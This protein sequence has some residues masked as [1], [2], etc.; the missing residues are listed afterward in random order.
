MGKH[1]WTE[2][3]S[4][5]TPITFVP[6]EL[7]FC[8]T[9]SR[10][11]RRR[12]ATPQG[13]NRL[14]IKQMRTSQKNQK[15]GPPDSAAKPYFSAAGLSFLRRLE[16][17]NRRDWFDPRKEEFTRE[18]KQPMLALIDAVNAA[19]SDFAPQHLRPA[20]KCMMRIYR[21]TRFSPDKR[22]YKSHVAAWW[23]HAGLEKT[24]GGGYYLHVSHK[25]VIVAA[26]VYMPEREQLLAIRT[27]LLEHHQQVRRVLEDKK[28]RRL[29]DSFSSMPLS[30]APKGFPK[31]HPAMDLLLCRQW[32]LSSRLPPEAALKP[33]LAREAILRFQ[34]AAPLVDALN[35]PLVSRLKQKPRPLFGLS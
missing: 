30:R 8:H 27:Y 4:W 23:S 3:P 2:G 20:A 10:L 16:R 24:S 1:V 5:I 11:R 13:A 35:T 12:S 29:M 32:G 22:P 19:M 9:H 17:N 34:L 7:S 21:D 15:S 14:T 6:P 25:E 26:G 33:S 28:L 31:E 18:L